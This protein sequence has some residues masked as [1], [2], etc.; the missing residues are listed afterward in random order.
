MPSWWQAAAKRLEFLAKEAE[1]QAGAKAMGPEV[2]K[3][4]QSTQEKDR[5]RFEVQQILHL[6][7][8]VGVVTVSWF[9]MLLCDSAL[10]HGSWLMVPLPEGD[11]RALSGTC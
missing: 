4:V 8:F 5:R 11:G 3:L 6:I 10:V 1:L 7:D 9:V 2:Q